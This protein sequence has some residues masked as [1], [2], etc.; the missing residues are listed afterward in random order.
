MVRDP[1]ESRSVAKGVLDAIVS[2]AVS[3]DVV[4]HILGVSLKSM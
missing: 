2:F 1:G 3:L 4:N